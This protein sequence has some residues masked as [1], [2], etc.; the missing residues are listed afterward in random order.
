VTRVAITGHR[1]FDRRTAELVDSDIRAELAKLATG[2]GLVGISCLADGADQ[3]FAK[4]VLEVG[5]Q[6]EVIVPARAYRD[7]LPSEAQGDYDALLAKATTIRRLDYVESTEDAHMAASVAMLTGSDRLLAV[8]DG[9]P[10]RGLGGTGDVVEYARK[11][12]IPVT[13]IWPDDASRD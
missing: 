8:W 2:D 13:V 1:G 9:Q 11:Q 6:L 5:G 12:G 7:G 3:I 10:A 4:A